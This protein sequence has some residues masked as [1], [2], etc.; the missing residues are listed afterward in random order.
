MKALDYWID[1]ES[2]KL[3]TET[4]QQQGKVPEWPRGD[5]F[6]VRLRFLSL[7][8]TNVPSPYALSPATFT[9]GA[10]KQKDYAGDF[11]VFSDHDRFNRAGDWDE[12]SLEAGKLSV[13]V[14]LNTQALD[15]LLGG[16]KEGERLNFEIE[17]IDTEGH[18]STIARFPVTIVNDVI[19]GNEGIVEEALPEYYTK[20]QADEKFV[21]F[22]LRGTVNLPPNDVNGLVDLGSMPQHVFVS[23]ESN[24][25]VVFA[26]VM[27]FEAGFNYFLSGPP[28][29][30]AK[31]HWMVVS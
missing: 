12:A 3:V 21:E 2:G 10:K 8:N 17:M 19:K 30:N 5:T 28:G 15:E 14:N 31:L 29:P 22:L 25:L 7:T 9:L 1:V 20:E 27:L 18:A 23:V 24:N 11:Q 13:L 26:S 16:D 4:G 6:L